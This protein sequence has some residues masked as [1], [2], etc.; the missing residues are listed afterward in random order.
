MNVLN[1]LSVVPDNSLRLVISPSFRHLRQLQKSL[2]IEAIPHSPT[3]VRH[4]RALT[5][6]TAVKSA[7]DLSVSQL[8]FNGSKLMKVIEL[9]GEGGSVM[10]GR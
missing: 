1:H 3:D 4:A 6:P 7:S 5:T 9:V 10:E 2:L 8:S